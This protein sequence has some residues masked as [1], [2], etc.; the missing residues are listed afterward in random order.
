MQVIARSLKG[1]TSMTSSVLRAGAA[2]SARVP[3]PLHGTLERGLLGATFST[4][5]NALIFFLV[6][7]GLGVTDAALDR[8]QPTIVLS[9][10]GALGATLVFAA[11]ERAAEQPVRT[12]CVVALAVLLVSWVPD[13]FLTG[14]TTAWG[15]PTLMAM[16]VVSGGIMVGALTL[17][18]AERGDS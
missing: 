11:L 16:H 17:R 2:K 10:L 5:V 9:F 15:V 7:D 1:E 18:H 13:F 12:F 3:G 6:V 4:A 14:A 8:V